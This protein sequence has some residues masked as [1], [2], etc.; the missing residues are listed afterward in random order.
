MYSTILFMVETSLSGLCGSGDEADVGGGQVA[1][2]VLV[3][4]PAGELDVVRRGRAR[5]A[6]A[7][8]CVE[9]VA[10]RR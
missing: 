6:S 9:G 3:G 5:A 8:I 7:T 4:D 2:Q 1:Q 10:R